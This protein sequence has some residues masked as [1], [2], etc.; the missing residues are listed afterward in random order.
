MKLGRITGKVWATAKDP[1]LNSLTLYVM[2]PVDENDKPLGTELI[3]V[4]TVG[5]REGDLVYWVGGA[6]ATF[7][8]PDRQI[9]SDATIVGLVD[10]LDT[11]SDGDA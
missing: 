1:K 10:R 7:P 2:Q 3:A 4:D 11:H 8:F 6:E 5:S 9:P